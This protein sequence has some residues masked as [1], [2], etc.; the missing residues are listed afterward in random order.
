LLKRKI[1]QAK[2]HIT[3]YGDKK[4]LTD[5]EQG[6][7]NDAR[8]LLGFSEKFTEQG[9]P[10]ALLNKV[11][12]G[13]KIYRLEIADHSKPGIVRDVPMTLLHGAFLSRGGKTSQQMA[14]EMLE[15]NFG[16][17]HNAYNIHGG[18]MGTAGSIFTDKMDALDKRTEG[19]FRYGAEPRPPKE[20]GTRRDGLETT[21]RVER[22]A[23]FTPAALIEERDRVHGLGRQDHA[24]AYHS[25]LES[26]LKGTK[27]KV[28]PLPPPV[29]RGALSM[30]EAGRITGPQLPTPPPA[31][32][33]DDEVQTGEPMSLAWDKIL[34]NIKIVQ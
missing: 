22:D 14:S 9:H 28:P 12:T 27:A 5:Y 8:L 10:I 31:V 4:K 13:T 20:D 11:Q 2:G 23:V 1:G 16:T 19:H 29:E 17:D 18:V 25:R 30:E 21:D 24:E 32:W 6:K 15:N 34:K 7:L 3:K 26:A 33:D